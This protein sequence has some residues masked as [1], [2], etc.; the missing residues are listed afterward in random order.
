MEPSA[1]EADLVASGRRSGG[2][3]P[4][5]RPRLPNSNQPNLEES[6]DGGQ[7]T[8]GR[9]ITRKGVGSSGRDSVFGKLR[10]IEATLPSPGFVESWS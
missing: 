6:D 3:V 7:E 8:D 1:E 4:I 5:E 9:E 10:G 2:L